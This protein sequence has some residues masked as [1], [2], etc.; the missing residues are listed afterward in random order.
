MYNVEDLHKSILKKDFNFFLDIYKN[1]EKF[2][3]IRLISTYINKKSYLKIKEDKIEYLK[4]NLS[5]ALIS[6]IESVENKEEI[7]KLIFENNLELKEKKIIK[8]IDRLTKFDINKIEK[9]FFKT[10]LK[11]EEEH[12]LRYANEFYLRD[13]NLFWEN[14]F[15]YSLINETESLKA[16]MC[17][18]LYNLIKDNKKDY[19]NSFYSII[20]YIVLRPTEIYNYTRLNINY[21]I[22]N[23]NNLIENKMELIKNNFYL[24]TYIYSTYFFVKNFD[25]NK[26]NIIL[27]LLYHHIENLKDNNIGL[28]SSEE[29]ILSDFYLKK[30]KEVKF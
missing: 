28:L 7:L 17:L 14:I 22:E 24:L 16:F 27:N 12:A 18:N 19:L 15:F 29:L 4:A 1:S 9:N 8:K 26:K 3:F 13:E 25:S 2:E 5:L 20:N 10:F 21:P 30:L 11:N 6:I 23:L